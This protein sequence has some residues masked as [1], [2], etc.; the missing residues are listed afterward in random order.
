[1]SILNSMSRKVHKFGFNVKKHSPEILAV[2]GT[3]GVV[4]SAVMACKATTKLNDILEDSKEDIDLIH[5][6]SEDI[7]FCEKHDYTEE[8][9]KKD[10]LIVY[11]QTGIKMVK[12]YG[13]SIALGTLSL[14]CLLQSSNILRKRNVAL[15]AAYATVDKGFKQYRGRVVERFGDA[16]DRELRYNIKAKE[17]EE[18]VVNENG[19]ETVVKKT[20]NV[21][22]QEDISEFGRKFSQ[23]T[24]NRKGKTILNPYWQPDNDY[25]LVFL[26]KQEQFANQILRSKGYLILNDVYDMLGLSPTKVGHIIGWIYCEDEANPMGDN[27][28]DFGLNNNDV[29]FSDEDESTLVLDFNVDGSIWEYM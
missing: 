13:P 12:L 8:D 25:N 5:E 22:N 11:A 18:I 7:D 21:V 26:K 10:L 24:V 16:V 19:N 17:V 14:G 20:I 2:T 3:I 29:L 15:A 9:T 1:M 28:I 4:A 23:Y 27:Y 6:K